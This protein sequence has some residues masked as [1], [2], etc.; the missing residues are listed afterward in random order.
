MKLNYRLWKTKR[1]RWI[2]ALLIVTFAATWGNMTVAENDIEKGL[3]QRITTQLPADVKSVFCYQIGAEPEQITSELNCIYSSDTESKNKLGSAVIEVPFWLGRDLGELDF[4]KGKIGM[5]DG[6][7]LYAHSG[8]KSRNRWSHSEIFCLQLLI[9]R[10]ASASH[11]LH[12]LEPI[13]GS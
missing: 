9:D 3:F 5:L 8:Y 11:N 2:S 1:S 7:Y 6:V 13:A 4:V 10:I 12:Q